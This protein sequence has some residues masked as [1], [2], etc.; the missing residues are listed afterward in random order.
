MTPCDA[1]GREQAAVRQRLLEARRCSLGCRPRAALDLTEAR[2]SE[3][4]AERPYRSVRSPV[5]L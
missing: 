1:S 4:T 2:F 3:E 5:I